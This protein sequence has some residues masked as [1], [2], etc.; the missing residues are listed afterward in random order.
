MMKQG[1]C[2]TTARRSLAFLAIAAGALA[3]PAAAQVARVTTSVTSVKVV[4]VTF[5]RLDRDSALSVL[6]ANAVRDRLKI[7]YADRF[8]AVD[9]RLIDT[10]LVAAGFPPDMPLD[11]TLARQLARVLNARLLLEGVI[12]QLGDDSIEVVGRLSEVTQTLPQSASASVRLERRRAGTGTGNEIANRLADSFRSFEPAKQCQAFRQAQDFA[13]ALNAANDALRRY[14]NSSQALLCMAQ[15]MRAQNAPPDTVIRVL[16]RALNSDSMNVLAQ[17]QLM[18]FYEERNDTSG[19]ILTMHHILIADANNNE[20]RIALVRLHIARNE[21]DSALRILNESLDRNPNQADLLD[22]RSRV[23]SMMSRFGDAAADLVHVGQV[24][25]TKVDSAL[26]FRIWSN[27]KLAHDTASQLAWGDTATRRF[28]TQTSY[29]YDLA[30]LRRAKGDSAGSMQ[31]I[32]GYLRVLPNDARGNL[33]YAGYLYDAG[34]F[35]SAQVRALA[36]AA[37]DSTLRGSAAAIL[38]GIGAR[39]RAEH[40]AEAAD[41]LQ[42]AK[43]WATTAPPRTREQIAFFLGI[44][45]YQ[46]AVAADSAAQAASGRDQTSA[47]CDA[48]RREAGL[49]DQ[50]EA[51]VTAG[52]RTA[53]E[54]AQQILTQAV[55]AY[56]QRAVAFIR[57]ARCPAQ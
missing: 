11:P 30:Q 34:Q 10:N 16:Q 22:V 40:P 33:V 36:A 29:W 42:R 6:I 32:R 47:R 45:Q 25:S 43:D 1:A 28:P 8:N 12:L 19:M 31:A 48:A 54:T 56:R 44:A 21:P 41:L 9:K 55:P 51:N 57:T 46:L 52:G 53:P 27:F 5:S 20:V 4:V 2:V 7:A 23:H 3:V 18:R 38:F 15:V 37:A 24:D 49:I 35:D 13:K 17:W 26:V 50:V 14:Q 39:L